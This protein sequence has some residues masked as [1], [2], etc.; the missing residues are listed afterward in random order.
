MVLDDFSTLDDLLP[1][2]SVSLSY[3][4]LYELLRVWPVPCSK[5]G[6]AALEVSSTL[7]GKRV[8]GIYG[9]HYALETLRV[10]HEEVRFLVYQKPADWLFLVEGAHVAHAPEVVYSCEIGRRASIPVE[11]PISDPYNKEILDIAQKQGL[12]REAMYTTLMAEMYKMKPDLDYISQKMGGYW[13]ISPSYLK[14]LLIVLDYYLTAGHDIA[15]KKKKEL[16]ESW[17]T[18]AAISNAVSRKKAEKILVQYP[19]KNYLFVLV[20]KGHKCVFEGL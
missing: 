15:E 6:D 18:I 10:L 20:G 12:N 11:D 16:D 3:N 13:N 9:F 17:G 4:E 14:G 5:K 1:D 7:A 2:L 8:Y 19:N